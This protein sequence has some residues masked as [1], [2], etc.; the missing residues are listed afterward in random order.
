MIT[1]IADIASNIFKYADKILLMSA[2]II[3]HKAFAK[4]LGITDYKYIEV[5]S[6]FNPANSPIYISNKVKINYKNLK[7]VLPY[8]TEQINKICQVHKMHKGVIHTHT[9]QITD[10]LKNNLKGGG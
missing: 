9:M 2:T 4:T 6:T 10:Y 1:D 3:D 5:D 8:L 7:D